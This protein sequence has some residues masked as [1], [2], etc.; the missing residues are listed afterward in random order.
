MKINIKIDSSEV[1]QNFKKSSELL[2]VLIEE[3]VENIAKLLVK[4][5]RPNIPLLTGKL[6]DSGKI[7]KMLENFAFKLVWDAS[8][9]SNN[10]S[11]AQRQYQE[12]LQHIDGKYAAKWVE[13][14]FENNRQYYLTLLQTNFSNAL[15]FLLLGN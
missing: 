4:D 3:N 5:S 12:V 10:Y 6:R 1:L 13:K 14:T 15:N 9:L 7:E 8:N 11:Y 2:H